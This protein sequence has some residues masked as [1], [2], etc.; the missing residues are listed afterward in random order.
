MPYELRLPPM[1]RDDITEYLERFEG[2]QKWEALEQ[3]QAELERL[4][5]NPQLGST[6]RGAFGRPI[7][8]F[9]IR[10]DGVRYPIRVVY[11]YTPDERAIII[12]GFSAQLF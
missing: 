6:P 7:Y 5:A 9:S 11:A 1:V 12:G 3:I 8:T 4:A 2:E 10:A